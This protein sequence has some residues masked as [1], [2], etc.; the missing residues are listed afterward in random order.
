M[1]IH[2]HILEWPNSYVTHKFTTQQSGHS[3]VGPP[4]N[5]QNIRSHKG[6]S[7]EIDEL[8]N[9]LGELSDQLDSFGLQI[10]E[11]STSLESQNDKI[12][13]DIGSLEEFDQMVA[14]DIVELQESIAAVDNYDDRIMHN[15]IRIEENS[16]SIK[17]GWIPRDF[18]NSRRGILDILG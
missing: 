1:V 15:A 12:T 10:E 13:E 2:L 18:W 17:L 6:S 4:Y 7:D 8:R 16:N 5:L 3:N 9:S 11:L 14:N